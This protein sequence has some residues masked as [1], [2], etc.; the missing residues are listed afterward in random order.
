MTLMSEIDFQISSATDD[1]L[2]LSTVPAHI[3]FF[4]FQQIP[5]KFN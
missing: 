3:S 1:V 4:S 2:K 5:L